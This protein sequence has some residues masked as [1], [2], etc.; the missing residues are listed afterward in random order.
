MLDNFPRGTICIE[1]LDSLFITGGLAARETGTGRQPDAAALEAFVAG[2]Q[3]AP[4][5]AM[6][7]LR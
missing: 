2:A 4:T 7:Y 5:F 1:D 3:I 6:G